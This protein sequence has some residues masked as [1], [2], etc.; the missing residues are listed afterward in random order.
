MSI[1]A[2]FVVVVCIAGLAVWW[3]ALRAGPTADGAALATVIVPDLSGKA[4]L[5]EPLFDDYCAACHGKSAAGRDGLAP[6]LVHKIYEPSHHSDQAFY[7]AIQNGVRA[8]HWSFGN[9]PQVTGIKPEQVEPIVA[10]VRTLQRAN[11]IE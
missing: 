8:H 1:A 11:G 6:P 2:R 5:G 10:Y 4:A 3:F 9:M 7:L